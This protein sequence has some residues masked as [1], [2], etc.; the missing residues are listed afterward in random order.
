MIARMALCA[1]ALT[2]CVASAEHSNGTQTKAE[3]ELADALKDR[4]A[5]TPVDCID[6][7]QASGGPQIIDN[8]TILYRQVGKTIWRN[9]LKGGCP[10]LHQGDTLV[11]EQYGSQLC[12]N[13]RFRSVTP[14]SSIPGATCLFGKFTPYT[15]AK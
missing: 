10:G 5:G 7:F 14:G 3:R 9:D 6:T 1:L 11:V 8:N 15:K 4:V 13:D 12:R 2:G